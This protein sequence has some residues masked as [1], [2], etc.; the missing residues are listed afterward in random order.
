MP[1]GFIFFTFHHFVS[2]LSIFLCTLQAYLILTINPLRS[3]CLIFSSS[4]PVFF[5][6]FVQFN[7]SFSRTN[8]LI[9]IFIDI[10]GL[11]LC[12]NTKSSPNDYSRLI[13]ISIRLSLRIMLNKVTRW[14]LA[15]RISF[16][17]FIFLAKLIFLVI[18]VKI[19]R[20]AFKNFLPVNLTAIFIYCSICAAEIRFPKNSG[21][22]MIVG[23]SLKKFITL[24]FIFYKTIYSADFLNLLLQHLLSQ[25]SKLRDVNRIFRNF[26][27]LCLHW[28]SIV[29]FIIF[30]LIYWILSHQLFL[31]LPFLAFRYLS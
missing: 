7:G 23:I 5:T 9:Y 1:F 20:L 16:G 25:R 27:K 6:R 28:I 12:L 4:I 31:Y 10:L 22:W 18:K 13:L 30:F 8:I 2:N 14:P 26:R 15:L 24:F 29:I 21:R 3:W 11:I 17:F 19:N